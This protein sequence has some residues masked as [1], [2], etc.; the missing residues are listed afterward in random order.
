[1]G[2]FSHYQSHPPRLRFR[3]TLEWLGRRCVR[4]VPQDIANEQ[5]R[6]RTW[7]RLIR[8]PPMVA[9]EEISTL[10]VCVWSR[11]VL[12]PV[13]ARCLSE[14]VSLT[15]AHANARVVPV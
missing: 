9:A 8:R 11:Q 6:L 13:I 14:K 15:C 3:E 1:M 10:V 5:Y 2:F 4:L 7:P 12:S